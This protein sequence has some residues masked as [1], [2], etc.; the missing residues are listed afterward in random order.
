MEKIVLVLGIAALLGASVYMLNSEKSSQLRTTVQNQD[1]ASFYTQWKKAYN[2][3]YAS[4]AQ[5]QYRFAV[6]SENYETIAA[7]QQSGEQS[8]TLD[9]N[10]FMDIT[11]EEFAQTYLGT[12]ESQ[13]G[14]ETFESSEPAPNAVDWRG[15]GVLNEVR[16]QGACGSC[17]AFSAVGTIEAAHAVQGKG[18]PAVSEQELVDCSKSYGNN[19]C[20]GGLM[21]SAFQYVIAKGITKRSD[22]AYAGRDQ[23]CQK[24]S[25]NYKISKF[26]Q[27]T[28][29]NCG[30]LE[31]AVATRPV[32]VAVD[33]S[34]WQFYNSGVFNNCKANLNHGVVL[35]GFTANEWVIRN[36]WAASWGEQGHIRLAKGNTC[37]V[38]ADASYPVVWKELIRY[39]KY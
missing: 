9:F 8:Y 27:V 13:E 1:L 11:S 35:V 20:N 39:S 14:G 25:A 18:L 2:K 4:P 34:N 30:S 5:D 15:K 37:G 19:G 16:N 36:S 29:G 23:S 33:A 7:F 17:W 38:C 3:K 12:H 6:F 22:Y 32:S 24:Q 31:Q 26:V 28:K 21:T 10:Q